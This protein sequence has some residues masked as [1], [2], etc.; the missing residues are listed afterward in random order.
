MLRVNVGL[1][2]KV[3]KDYNSTGYS[4]NLDGEVA[5]PLDDAE[6]VVERIKELW[7][8]AE[9]AL[10]VEVERDQGDQAIGSRDAEPPSITTAKPN[11]RSTS[12]NGGAGRGY[13]EGN[14]TEQPQKSEEA[15]TNKQVQYLLGIGQRLRLSTVQLEGKIAEIIGRKTGLYELT[16]REAGTVIDA[17]TQNANGNTRVAARR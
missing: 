5:A 10:R 6:A 1:S 16:K 14:G 9:E 12:D 8:L 15:A 2:R 17:L 3:T 7:S 13:G 4:V 11:G